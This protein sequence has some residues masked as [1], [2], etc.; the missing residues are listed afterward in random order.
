VNPSNRTFPVE[1]GLP[2]PGRTVKPEMVANVEVVRRTV[3]NAL[4]VAQDALVRVEDG[5]VAYVVV[6]SAENQT[7]EARSVTTGI[8]QRNE[9]VVTSG[10]SAGDR[11]VVVGQKLV[12]PGDRVRVVSGS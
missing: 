11:L 5:Y 2:N 6:G 10:L 1:F 9:V 8:T 4:V 3:R 12:A 7:V